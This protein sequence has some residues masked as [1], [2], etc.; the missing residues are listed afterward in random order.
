VTGAASIFIRV[1]SLVGAVVLA[2]LL[3]PQAFGLVAMA[4]IILQ[5]TNLFSGLGMRAAVV[6]SKLDRPTLA[7]HAFLIC[8]AMGSAL[9]LAVALNTGFLA[10]ALGDPDVA[11]LLQWMSLIILLDALATVPETL[12]RKDLAFA[13]HSVGQAAPELLYVVM[14][15]YLASAGFGLWSLAYAALARS[16]FGLILFWSICPG[17]DWLKIRMPRLG[18]FQALLRYGFQVTL[19]G[20]FSFVMKTWDNFLVG[21]VLG[22]AAL[23]F[24]S[25]AFYFANLPAT[26]MEQVVG[27][28]LFASY[29]RLQDDKLR[30]TSAYLRSLRIVSLLTV[31]AML[32]IFVVAPQLV[33]VVLGAGW[34]PMVVSLQVLALACLAGL[35][36]RSTG[37]IYLALGRPGLNTRIA[38][39]QAVAV[40]GL[41]LGLVRF[42]IEGVAVAILSASIIG[43]IYSI[44]LLEHVLPGTRARIP[45]AIRST[46]AAGGAMTLVVYLV[47]VLIHDNGAI[48]PTALGLSG[49][50]ISGVIVY[51]ATLALLDR[52]LLKECVSLLRESIGRPGKTRRQS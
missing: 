20:I 16:A 17:W 8:A 35:I 33:P 12:L 40:V 24:Y 18:V 9:Y 29:A 48:D 50:I 11:A 32:G 45:G 3:D 23:G 14:A 6:H 43:L 1:I 30:L 41:T 5:T 27:S 36:P 28:V 42:G 26:S 21:R 15:V 47:D 38:V 44:V 39:L 13:R 22:S 49:S 7:F 4:T 52:A 37:P 25:R 2:R 19:T 46:F 31:P 51:L 10:R 34:E